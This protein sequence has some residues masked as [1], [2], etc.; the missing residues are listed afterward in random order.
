[1][2]AIG[3]VSYLGY[4]IAIAQDKARFTARVTRDGALIS[5][6][7]RNSEIWASESCGSYDR[8]IWVAKNAIDTGQIE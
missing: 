5:H 6:N 4:D 7:N 8:A 1:M 2:N 3:P